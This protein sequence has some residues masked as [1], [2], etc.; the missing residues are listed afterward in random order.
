MHFLYL[1]MQ[2]NTL[3][4]SSALICKMRLSQF[5]QCPVCA[6]NLNS[7]CF[8]WAILVCFCFSFEILKFNRHLLFFLITGPRRFSEAGFSLLIF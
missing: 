2:G 5:C 3:V 8:H 7:L 4:V 6:A 1:K